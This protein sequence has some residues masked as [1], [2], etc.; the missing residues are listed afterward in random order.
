MKLK[1]GFPRL[2]E[3]DLAT[4]L[5]RGHDQDYQQYFEL[6]ERGQPF[7]PCQYIGSSLDLGAALWNA[8]LNM[9]PP[10]SCFS[11]KA[12]RSLHKRPPPS[13][14]QEPYCRNF[15]HTKLARHYLNA[16]SNKTA[17]NPDDLVNW[18]NS[19][20]RVPFVGSGP[21]PG[22]RDLQLDPTSALA[23][24]VRA[25][26]DAAWPGALDEAENNLRPLLAQMIRTAVPPAYAVWSNWPRFSIRRGH[27]DEAM[28]GV[29]Q[30]ARSCCARPPKQ[31]H[32][33]QHQF[34]LT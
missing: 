11:R 5:N 15:S 14:W 29:G 23:R 21:D 8:L 30:G 28:D 33:S 25:R 12:I 16:Y 27:N 1:N 17:P 18:L 6:M 13:P 2:A 19:T 32:A 3:P 26:L 22:A 31:F 10:E 7:R 34:M 20:E 4:A 24:L 9:P